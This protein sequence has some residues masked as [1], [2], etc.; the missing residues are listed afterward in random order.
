MSVTCSR[1]VQGMLPLWTVL[2]FYQT[3]LIPWCLIP[4]ILVTGITT[5]LFVLIDRRILSHHC[6]TIVTPLRLSEGM[7][8]LFGL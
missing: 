6:C 8:H 7:S 1:L 5:I 3:E 4:F 2:L